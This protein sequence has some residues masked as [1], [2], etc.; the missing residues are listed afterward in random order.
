ML[1]G[2]PQTP[3]ARGAEHQ[4]VCAHR[5]VLLGQSIAE[6]RVID[7][8]VFACDSAFWNT[9]RAA[10][11]EDVDRFAFQAFRHPAADG[12]AAKPFVFKWREFAKV[13][14]RADIAQ[15]IEIELLL[16][17]E[18]KRAAGGVVEMPGDGFGN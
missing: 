16:K 13:V 4:P 6:E 11:L 5:K 1:D 2:E 9:G 17:V 18:P 15:W 7:S 14:E 8:K 10:G 3:R 12:P